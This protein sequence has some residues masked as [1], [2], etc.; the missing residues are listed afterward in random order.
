M[1][2]PPSPLR[3][4][5][6]VQAVLQALR[7]APLPMGPEPTKLLVREVLEQARQRIL[8]GEAA[9]SL[10]QVLTQ[11]RARAQ[12]LLRG[13]LRRVINA[14]GVV[15]HTNLGRAPLG[16]RALE[17]L[18]EVAQHYSNLEYDLEEG[19]RGGRQ[20][21]VV[22]L[23]RQLTGAEDALVVNNNAA[24]LVLALSA[25]AAGREVVVSRGELV[26]IG[27]SFRIPEILETSG[28]RL[29]EVGATNRTR[30]ADYAGA[31]GAETA[32]LLKVHPSN[33]R[34]VGFTQA[35]DAAELAQLAH[36]RNILALEDL[37]S[38]C[39]VDLS[40]VGLGGEPT[41]RS[42]IAA[43]LDLITMSGDKLLGGPQAGIL[44]GRSSYIAR[45]RKHP[46]ARALRLDKLCLAA[47]EGTL[48]SIHAERLEDVPVLHMLTRSLAQLEQ[49]ARSLA[50]TLQTLPGLEVALQ[51]ADSRVGGGAFPEFP[52]P[53]CCV[54]LRH[55]LG[56][57]QLEARLRAAEVP[58]IVRQREGWILL[59]PR[60]LLPGDDA[61]I[62]TTLEQV[63]RGWSST[64]QVP[65]GRS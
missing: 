25:L 12:E 11:V 29:R 26:E 61:Q 8:Q 30:L 35:V 5:P 44:L 2:A 36:S 15:I 56:S 14:T 64:S 37:G 42:R 6:A 63:M 32:M 59:D 17:R 27:G 38:G 58:V 40:G 53:T 50:D 3:Q 18:Q 28:C 65:R 19:A 7:Q 4:L 62:L 16:A 55:P 31:I 43:G 49:D 52:L 13:Q 45:C 41:A 34:M 33:F 57:V 54:A 21:G 46:L 48:L 23:L 47:L 9:P 20:E 51:A 10:E 1:I 60:T 39:L 22:T 24:A